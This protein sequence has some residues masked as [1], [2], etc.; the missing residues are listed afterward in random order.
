MNAFLVEMIF[1]YMPLIVKIDFSQQIIHYVRLPIKIPSL[2]ILLYFILGEIK[3]TFLNPFFNIYRVY[4]II[5]VLF[6]SRIL[7]D[8]TKMY[9]ISTH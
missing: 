5:Y 4:N 7:A 1:R 9:K 2:S 8:T 3:I 6:G